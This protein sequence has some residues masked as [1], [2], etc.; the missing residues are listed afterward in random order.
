MT[1]EPTIRYPLNGS[2][3]ACGCTCISRLPMSSPH[4]SWI[5]YIGRRDIGG[6]DPSDSTT[7][8]SRNTSIEAAACRSRVEDRGKFKSCACSQCTAVE[9]EIGCGISIVN[10]IFPG[11]YEGLEKRTPR[12]YRHSVWEMISMSLKDDRKLPGTVILMSTS[13][14]SGP[15]H[16]RARPQEA[17]ARQRVSYWDSSFSFSFLFLIYA[18]PNTYGLNMHLTPTPFSH[19]P[20]APRRTICRTGREF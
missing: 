15:T 19:Q 2:S 9:M 17:S 6:G 5:V 10:K 11:V 13:T 12:K 20:A 7:S 1:G 4:W 3:E 16:T 18:M 8:E 14:G